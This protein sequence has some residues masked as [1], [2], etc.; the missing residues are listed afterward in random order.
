LSEAPSHPN[1]DA[2]DAIKL[3]SERWELIGEVFYLLAPD[4][5]G[6]SKLATGAERLLD[7]DATARNWRT[8]SKMFELANESG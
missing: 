4:G 7:V 1:G 6:R 5:F 8:V 2:L 3:K